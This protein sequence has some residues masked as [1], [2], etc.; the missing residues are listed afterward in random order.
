MP[1]H[2]LEHMTEAVTLTDER[3]F[4]KY[5]NPA[6][7]RTFGYA[8]GELLGQHITVLSA[9]PREE[10]DRRGAEVLAQVARQGRMD[11]RVDEPEERR[12]AVH[13]ARRASP[14]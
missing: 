12:L 4:L 9:Y 3:G 14:D 7:D 11:R 13:D 2:V 6:A 8:W 10:N 1:A 5:T